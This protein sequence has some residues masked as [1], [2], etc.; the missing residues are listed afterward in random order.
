M[1]FEMRAKAIALSATA[2]AASFTTFFTGCGSKSKDNEE[3]KL[4]I[5]DESNVSELTAE[6]DKT[7]SRSN[8]DLFK[9]RAV[10]DNVDAVIADATDTKITLFD[11]FK[12]YKNKDG[13]YFIIDKEEAYEL[14]EGIDGYKIIKEEQEYYVLTNLDGQRIMVFGGEEALNDFSKMLKDKFEAAKAEDKVLTIVNGLYV[15]D[16][17]AKTE[18]ERYDGTRTYYDFEGIMKACIAGIEAG[19][20]ADPI[21]YEK[22]ED[23][24]S[25]IVKRTAYTSDGAGGTIGGTEIGLTVPIGKSGEVYYDTSINMFLGMTFEQ[26][27]K[28]WI[29]QDTLYDLLGIDVMEGEYTVPGTTDSYNALIID[30]AGGSDEPKVV[31]EPKIEQSTSSGEGSNEGSSDAPLVVIDPNM[32]QE[33]QAPIDNGGNSGGEVSQAPAYDEDIK[34][35]LGIEVQLSG[36]NE[37]QAQQYYEACK[38]AYPSLPWYNNGNSAGVSESAIIEQSGFDAWADGVTDESVD[39]IINEKLAGRDYHDLS[40]EELAEIIPYVSRGTNLGAEISMYF[41]ELTH[42][43]FNNGGYHIMQ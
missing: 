22:S 7:G 27:G 17:V 28:F 34:N 42:K 33:Q 19:G 1:K 15:G 43:D 38:A 9:W 21:S 40:L 39:A 3:S 23:G 13:K 18:V 37:Q 10:K 4:T 5:I 41:S 12:I 35:K 31:V 8:S 14:I 6:K 26:D 11:S 2:I 29:C 36:S 25:W 24:K 30:T 20:Y 16:P 32:G